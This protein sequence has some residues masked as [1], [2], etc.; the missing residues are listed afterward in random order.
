MG[1][2]DD[3]VGEVVRRQCADHVAHVGAEPGLGGAPCALP[4]HHVVVEAGRF[5]HQTGRLGQLLGVGV[6]LV[7]DPLGQ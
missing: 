7:D 4:G 1:Q 3:G 2:T 5:R 6:A